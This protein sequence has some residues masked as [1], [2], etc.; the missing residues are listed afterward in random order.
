MRKIVVTQNIQ[1][2][3][4][5]LK[6]QAPGFEI[7]ISDDENI[8]QKALPD[9]EILLGWVEEAEELCLAPA[10]PLQWVQAWSA[11]VDGLPLQA[12]QN[13]GVVLTSASGVHRRSLSETAMG[14]LLGLARGFS[15]AA[16]AKAEGRWRQ[17]EVSAHP[18]VE[19]YGKTAG[20]LGTGVVGGEIARLCKA[21]GM[22]V[23]GVSRSGKTRENID[24]MFAH[25]DLMAVLPRCDYVVNS[26]PLTTQTR[27]CMGVAQFAAMPR[28]AQYVSVGR[29]PTTDTTALVQALQSGG[30]AGAGLDVVD[31][32]P[33]PAGSP[34]WKM[35]NVL[36]L[37]HIGGE[38]DRYNER[39]LEIFFAN[40]A[41][42]LA[43]KTPTHSKI[44]Y[45][46]AY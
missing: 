12:L 44:E 5:R 18:L 42:Y 25:K 41:Q 11:G 1:E 32:E 14:L 45:G 43:G 19:L 10:A 8:L 13:K 36:L 15:Y 17:D 38:T 39:L 6:K 7:L 33:L 31:P 16:A 28:H 4:P 34:L 20:V 40:L 46:R 21:F 23:L 9:A 27:H 24:E 22:Q 35:D 2:Y 30:I 26:M 29:G 3:M 37:P